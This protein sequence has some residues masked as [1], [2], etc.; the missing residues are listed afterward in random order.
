M[1]FSNIRARGGFNNNPT[2]A[3]FESAYKKILVHTELSSSEA[4]NCLALDETSILNVISYSKK[5]SDVLDII[6]TEDFE[7]HQEIFGLP[8]L[9]SY[10]TDVVEYIA[11]FVRKKLVAGL[12]CNTCAAALTHQNSLS[13]LLNRK[14][15]EGLMKP[16]NDVIYICKIAEKI[17][18]I[19]I[20]NFR[21]TIR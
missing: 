17:V 13:A 14:N 20:K 6:S 2:A 7:I 16:T 10:I 4:A 9:S 3:Q 18:R 11:G 8:D 12:N 5:T 1:F 21:K 15:K 19:H